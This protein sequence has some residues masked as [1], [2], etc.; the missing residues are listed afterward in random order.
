LAL[1]G[2]FEQLSYSLTMDVPTTY[3]YGNEIGIYMMVWLMYELTI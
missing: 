3:H 2:D 1:A